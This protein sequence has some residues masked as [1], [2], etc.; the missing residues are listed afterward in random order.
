MNLTEPQAAALSHVRAAYFGPE[1][2]PDELLLNRPHLQYAVGMLFPYESEPVKPA[3]PGEAAET[4]Q[5]AVDEGD[6]EEAGA[7]VPLAEDWRPSSVAIS[8]VTNSTS[9]VCRVSG[10]TY[11]ADIRQ[12]SAAV[13]SQSLRV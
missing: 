9:V 6:V 5:N 13:A 11:T 4:L 2:A 8:F 7:T 3:V 10:G 1:G 12:R